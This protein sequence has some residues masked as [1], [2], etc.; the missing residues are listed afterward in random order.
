[1]IQ[2]IL[3]SILW[4]EL[5]AG[6][7]IVVLYG[8]RQTGKTTLVRKLY[9]DHPDVKTISLTG[10]DPADRRELQGRDAA[11]LTHLV[12]GYQSLF[13]DEAQRITGI[14]LT[15]KLLHERVPSLRIIATGS[16]SF[17]LASMTTEPLTGRSR[18]FTLYPVAVEELLAN[19]EKHHVERSPDDYLVYGLYPEVR[20]AESREEKRRT[21]KDITEA[22]LYKD[23][24]EFGGIK[25]A[26]R[27]H[28]L[29]RLLAF[30]VGSEVSIAEIAQSLGLGRD[31]VDRYIDVLEKA[32][33]LF[34]HRGYSRNL[35]KEATKMDKIYFLDV[36]IRNMVIGNLAEPAM[37]DDMGR[38]WE[39][40]LAA[41][42]RKMLEYHGSYANSW[43]WRLRT[44]AEIDYVEEKDGVLR[45]Y[46][47]KYGSKVP[48]EPSAW[49]Q[50]YP[51][52]TYRVVNRKN[53]IGFACGSEE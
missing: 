12:A 34:R 51:G 36:G 19:T 33:V 6:K 9:S 21:L 47:F 52:S 24:I 20:N 10:D 17:E 28:D 45:G 15:L 4:S 27:I 31:T 8:P 25:H 2:R 1:M 41:E 18:T 39:N 26:D 35:R 16:S 3:E 43:F 42:R 14:G 22:Y 23:V 5:D 29:L 53:W 32:F 40:F 49:N 30:Q 48:R 50:T 46:E 7:K 37:R 11:T 13:I 44:G 38:I